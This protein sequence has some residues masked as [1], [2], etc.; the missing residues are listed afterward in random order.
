K[1]QRRKL[2][3]SFRLTRLKALEL[4]AF[5]QSYFSSTVTLVDHLDQIWI[6]NFVSNPFEFTSVL[7]SDATIQLEFE[8]VKQ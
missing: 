5:I 3:F 6:G 8:G 1:N 2:I 7:S 4:R